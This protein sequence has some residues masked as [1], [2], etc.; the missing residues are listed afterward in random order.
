MHSTN[1]RATQSSTASLAIPTLNLDCAGVM[2]G[3]NNGPDATDAKEEDDRS[4]PATVPTAAAAK[5]ELCGTVS[6]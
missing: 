6:K 3:R 5:I 2:E 4:A 1:G